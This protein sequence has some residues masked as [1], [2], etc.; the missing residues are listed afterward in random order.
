VPY[1]VAPPQ[2]R[3][4]VIQWLPRDTHPSVEQQGAPFTTASGLDPKGIRDSLDGVA[5][6]SFVVDDKSRKFN[7]VR[8]FLRLLSVILGRFVYRHQRDFGV[9]VPVLGV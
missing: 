1:K 8:L 2:D 4:C 5:Q 9:A 6:T 3:A 7:A